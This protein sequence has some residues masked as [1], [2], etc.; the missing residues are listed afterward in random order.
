MIVG[1]DSFHE[2]HRETGPAEGVDHDEGWREASPAP[3]DAIERPTEL[4]LERPVNG[5][6]CQVLAMAEVL[7]LMSQRL[8][9]VWTPLDEGHHHL[10]TAHLTCWVT[11]SDLRRDD[12]RPRLA[13]LVDPGTGEPIHEQNAPV[14]AR[15]NR[16][17]SAKVLAKHNVLHAR[18]RL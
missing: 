14:C 4:V 12:W 10:S 9:A 1:S 8:E 13:A 3:L 18:V 2:T 17:P 6:Q 16:Q 11:A 7:D 5:S 15:Q